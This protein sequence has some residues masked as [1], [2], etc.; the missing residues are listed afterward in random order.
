[1]VTVH[2]VVHV[3]LTDLP[4][5]L[6]TQSSTLYANNISKFLLSIGEKDHF[7]INLDDEVVRGS[8]ILNQGTLMWPPP[9]ISVAAKS[10]APAQSAQAKATQSNQSNL[11]AVHPFNDTLKKSTSPMSTS[12]ESTRDELIDIFFMIFCY[13]RLHIYGRSQWSACVRLCLTES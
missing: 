6:A 2:D 4:S 11:P 10:V 1:M 12:Q 8:I 9:M 13:C 5:R 3:G 7:Y